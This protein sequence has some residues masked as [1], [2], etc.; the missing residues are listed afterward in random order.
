MTLELPES[1]LLVLDFLTH[2]GPMN[3]REIS[4]KAKVPLRTVSFALKHLRY[5]DICKRIPNFA[6]MRRPLYTV[7]ADKARAV[8]LKYGKMMS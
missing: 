1:A 2:N 7:D 8:F 6:D 3:P 5:H 4:R